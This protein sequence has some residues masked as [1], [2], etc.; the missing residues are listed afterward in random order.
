MYRLPDEEEAD[1]LVGMCVR[2]NSLDFAARQ[3]ADFAVQLEGALG[4]KPGEFLHGARALYVCVAPR[5]G[6]MGVRY[7]A[8][9]DGNA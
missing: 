9:K 3:V 4:I 2:V 1:P 6:C 8:Q 7:K 5:T